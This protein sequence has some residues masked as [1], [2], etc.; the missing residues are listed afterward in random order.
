MPPLEQLERI[1]RAQKARDRTAGP[2]ARRRVLI[3]MSFVFYASV[4]GKESHYT[5]ELYNYTTIPSQVNTV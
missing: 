2:E 1:K 3:G 4:L 5:A